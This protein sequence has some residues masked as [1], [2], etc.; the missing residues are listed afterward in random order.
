MST[1]TTRAAIVAAGVLA[2]L[3]LA[4]P[5]GAA[6]VRG[7]VVHHNHQA[8]SFTVAT[9][10]G[11]LRAIH[12]PRKP[13]VGR[14]VKVTARQLRNG[15]F[16]AKR[17]R[18]GAK[19]RRARIRGT[20]TYVNRRA[21]RFV[22]SARGVSLAVDAGGG[23]RAVAA[24]AMPAVGDRVT[25]DANLDEQTG[26][27]AAQDVAS[28]GEDGGTIELEGVVQAIDAE[29]GILTISGDD[30]GGSGSLT[31]L[32]PAG[33]DASVYRVGDSVELRAT[34]NQDGT[35]SAVGS[36]GDANAKEA[37]NATDDQ[38]EGDG[39][40]D[41]SVADATAT[42]QAQQADANF[43]AT[44]DGKSFAQFY[45]PEDTMSSFDKCVDENSHGQSSDGSG[46]GQDSGSGS[47]QDS[48]SGSGQDSGSG[49][50]Q[51]SG[52]D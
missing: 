2:A 17:V 41:P 15:T 27:V 35:Y 42:C 29:K 7:I 30:E 11:A 1:I 39:H 20:V 44:H 4:A 52:G 24:S 5:A 13:A 48:G 47:G 16:A 45:Q 38:G 6:T 19:H 10:N 8:G 31:V 21:R 3:A 22:V 36:S 23:G 33:F 49:S 40:R 51:D 50:G 25:V 26:D 14:S 12:G 37:D 34:L 46:S 28:H 18:V 32:L 43:P 9:R